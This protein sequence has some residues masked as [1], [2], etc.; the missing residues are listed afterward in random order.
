M[1]MAAGC[2]FDDEILINCKPKI[3][4]RT[5]R[6]VFLFYNATETTT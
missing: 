2:V 5:N 4:R 3:A 6:R 1:K